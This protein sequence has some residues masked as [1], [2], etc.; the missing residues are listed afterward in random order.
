VQ[1]QAQAGNRGGRGAI[2]GA[3]Q[4]GRRGH[5]GVHAG[6]GLGK[7][8]AAGQCQAHGP[9]HGKVT[10][11]LSRRVR[12]AGPRPGGRLQ[13]HLRGRGQ[14]YSGPGGPYGRGEP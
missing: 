4:A 14:D 1:A 2:G 9:G 6:A 8:T 11:R 10:K 5:P 7:W 3:A 13:G 12:Q